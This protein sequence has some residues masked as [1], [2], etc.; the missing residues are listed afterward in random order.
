MTNFIHDISAHGVPYDISSDKAQNSHYSKVSNWCVNDS[1]S[2]YHF[3]TTNAGSIQLCDPNGTMLFSEYDRITT[4]KFTNEDN[5]IAYVCLK[6]K[7]E[8]K[9]VV[10]PI[11]AYTAVNTQANYS[12][13]I[14]SDTAYQYSSMTENMGTFN[15]NNRSTV[16]VRVPFKFTVCATRNTGVGNT[17]DFDHSKPLAKITAIYGESLSNLYVKGPTYILG[18]GIGRYPY[19]AT[20]QAFPYREY[21]ASSREMFFY[22][23]LDENS[24]DYGG[25]YLCPTNCKQGTNKHSVYHCSY[26]ES[27]CKTYRSVELHF[28]TTLYVMY[29]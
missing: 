6:N 19:Q 9:N 25:V 3:S 13:S 4:P 10:S 15:K 8:N 5:T 7:V 21:R 18:T 28:N 26:T 11:V 27:Q 22:I 29:K 24:S 2:S 16:S 17:P 23:N 1:D 14:G 20:N 12:L